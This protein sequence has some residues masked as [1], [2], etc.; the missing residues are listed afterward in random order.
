MNLGLY[1]NPALVFKCLNSVYTLLEYRALRVSLCDEER[2]STERI[3]CYKHWVQRDDEAFAHVTNIFVQ[4]DGHKLFN[5][6]F[7]YGSV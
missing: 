5:T 4:F 7:E 2:F 1:F 3:A 6:V